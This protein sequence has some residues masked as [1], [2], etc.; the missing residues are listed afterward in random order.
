VV[1]GAWA[2]DREAVRVAH[3]T[4]EHVAT[5]PGDDTTHVTSQ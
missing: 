2:T 1:L 3:R 5:P 4:D